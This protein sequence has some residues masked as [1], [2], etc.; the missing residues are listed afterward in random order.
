MWR[1]ARIRQTHFLANQCIKLAAQAD[2]K[3]A[4]VVRVKFDILKWF[5]AKFNPETFGDRPQHLRSKLP[6]T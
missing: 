2:P 6:S 1:D 3:T 5:C 4:H